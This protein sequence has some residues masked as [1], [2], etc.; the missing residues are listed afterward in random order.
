MCH[1][2]LFNFCLKHFLVLSTV[3]KIFEWM[4]SNESSLLNW[5]GNRTHLD[6]EV[7][8]DRREERKRHFNTNDDDIDRGRVKKVKDHRTYEDRSN[9]GYNP[10][11]EYQNGKTWDRSL[12]N[13]HRRQYYNTS[14]HSRQRHGRQY[15]SAHYRY[16]SHSR[17][18]WQRE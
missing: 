1:V 2:K 11:Q 13:Y 18:H 10:F 3:L 5:N 16:H 7:D 6:R 17:A 14:T 15:R 12:N 4:Y 9:T 8:N